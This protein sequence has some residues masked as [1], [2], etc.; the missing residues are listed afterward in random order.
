[1]KS[2]KGVSEAIT[3]PV[4]LLVEGEDEEYIVR[5]MCLHW[6]QGRTQH[7]DIESVGGRDNFPKRFK[8]L[9]VRS[10]GPL[11]V[12]GVIADSEEDAQATSQRWHVLFGEVEPKVNRPCRK[13]QLPNE[14]TQG[15]FESLV[16]QA[17]DGDLVVACATAFRD[18]VTPQ[19]G[20]KTQAQKDKIAVQAWLSALLGNAY[21]NIFKAQKDYPHQQLLNY[22]HEAFLPI[23]RFL[24]QLLAEV[25]AVPA[26]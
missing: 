15:A 24:E 18:C 19:L 5:A 1:M 11:K 16:L 12:V 13:L 3:A 22:D 6:F 10:P 7:I 4:L 23:K 25:D 14:A 8:A 17:L 21:G 9:A 2:A 20:N 26:E